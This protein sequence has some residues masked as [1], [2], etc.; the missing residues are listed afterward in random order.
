M[1]G[2]KKT[3][4]VKNKNKKKIRGNKNK[5]SMRGT[6]VCHEGTIENRDRRIENTTTVKILTAVQHHPKNSTIKPSSRT[7]ICSI[8][9]KHTTSAHHISAY[10][11]SFL[12]IV[13]CHFVCTAVA[14]FPF[15]LERF[16]SIEDTVTR[17][18]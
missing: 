2:Y 3:M 17:A 16:I 12:L 4:I 5:R 13:Q 15:L 14:T 18:S 11:S 9:G 10:F 7:L 1:R 6:E 8:M